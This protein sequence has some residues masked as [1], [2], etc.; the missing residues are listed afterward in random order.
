MR[1]ITFILTFMLATASFAQ[2]QG[3]IWY[4]GEGAGLDFNS[5]SPV[6]IAGGQTYFID[7]THNEGCSAMSDSSGSILFYSNGMTA[8]NRNHVIMPNGDSLLGNYSSTQSSL[9]VPQPESDR[10]FYLFTTDAF[11]CGS[12]LRN[13][14]R[15]SKIDM[16]LDNTFGDIMAT[17]K[18]VLL[19]DTVAEKVAATKHANG[20]D[21]WVITHKYHSNAF[22]AFLLTSSGI[23]DTVISNIGSIHSGGISGSQGQMKFSSNGQLLAIAA[24]NGNDLAELFDFD[25]VTGTISNYKPLNRK[26][27]GSVYGVEFSS[28]N[29]KLYTFS[30]SFSPYGTDLVQ[31]DLNAGGGNTDSINASLNTIYQND[32]LIIAKGLQIAPDGK[33]YMGSATNNGYLAVINN[34]NLGGAA[35]NFQD[36][37]IYLLGASSSITLPGFI[38]NYDYSNNKVNCLTDVSNVNPAFGKFKLY[39]NPADLHTTFEFHNSTQEHYTLTLHNTQGQLLRM[40]TNITSNK[41]IIDTDDLTN[42]MYFIQLRSDSQTQYTGKLTIE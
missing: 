18:N 40:I 3:N 21:Y 27:N 39:P 37:S 13:G 28:D 10:Y 23:S 25:N 2:N 1:K 8:W 20:D 33:I 5:V 30:W 31:Y 17:E 14:F 24:S 41:I 22:Y 38:A 16:C 36:Q 32:S 19:A 35:C 4:F 12:D 42:G 9:I 15:Y 11:C 34:P 6:A 7:G 26:D 29:S